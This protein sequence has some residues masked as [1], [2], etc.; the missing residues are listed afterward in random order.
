MIN[1][2]IIDEV[3]KARTEILDSYNGN[4]DAM[5]RDMMKRQHTEGRRVVK[6]SPEETKP[7]IT[8]NPKRPQA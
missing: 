7:G 8:R 1:N 3:R 2:P 6:L 5:L 4:V